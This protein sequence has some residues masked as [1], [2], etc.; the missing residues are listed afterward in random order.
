MFSVCKFS[1]SRFEKGLQERSKNKL[2]YYFSSIV[3]KKEQSTLFCK[4]KPRQS[5]LLSVF[6]VV[7]TFTSQE[8]ITIVH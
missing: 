7:L 3:S 8:L 1:C 2:D 5:L 4:E 6:I